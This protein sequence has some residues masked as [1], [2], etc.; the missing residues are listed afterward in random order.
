MAKPKRINQ[1]ARFLNWGVKSH[2]S[3]PR[4]TMTVL[5]E[6]KS[7]TPVVLQV[8]NT[9]KKSTSIDPPAGVTKLT[10]DL[11]IGDRVKVSYDKLNATC[12]Y[13][14][15]Q[16]LPPASETAPQE[17]FR[18]TYGF[19]KGVKHGGEHYQGFVVTR[20]PLN[21]TML[22]PNT[23]ADASKKPSPAP[24]LLEKLKKL[25]RGDLVTL[26]YDPYKYVFAL[27][28]IQAAKQTGQAVFLRTTQAVRGGKKC[29][30]V[31]IR[32]GS[33]SLL[34]QVPTD[35]QGAASE[36]LLTTVKDLKPQQKVS[37]TYR[38]EGG[39]CWLDEISAG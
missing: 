24:A 6:T 29:Q 38:R 21:W 28:D 35:G 14:S 34:L 10:G 25:R 2:S 8:A 7:A 23:E 33:T 5:P 18:F 32:L 16:K 15:G 30:L 4:L 11:K 31:Q 22:L 17:S 13:V 39:L 1:T 12:T 36:G 19:L 27:K 37:V 26:D 9:K 3:G 20:G